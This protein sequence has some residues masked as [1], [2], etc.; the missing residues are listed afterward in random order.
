MASTRGASR[1][2]RGSFSVMPR[3]GFPAFLGVRPICSSPARLLRAS[4]QRVGTPRRHST[5]R[6]ARRPWLDPVN[7]PRTRRPRVAWY[8][9]VSGLLET[10]IRRDHGSLLGFRRPS[11]R[12]RRRADPRLDGRRVRPKS[13]SAS[14]RRLPSCPPTTSRPRPRIEANVATRRSLA[15][16][17]ATPGYYFDK[18]GGA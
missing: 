4:P 16:P 13:R 10:H 6:R 8:E 1:M 12:K 3:R 18:V 11:C 7:T 5:P 2:R 9:V 15:M 17:G 14:R